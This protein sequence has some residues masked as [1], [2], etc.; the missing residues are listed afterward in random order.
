MD[1]IS[2][3]RAAYLIPFIDVLRDIGAPVTRDLEQAKLPAM[4]EETP[5]EFVSNVLI[6]DY[7]AKSERREDIDDLGWLWAEQF[8]ASIFSAELLA[9]LQHLPTVKL[10]LD[11]FACLS[12]LEDSDVSIGIVESNG[13]AEVF[14][15]IPPITGLN[16]L[17]ISEWT[18]VTALIETIR[19]ITGDNWS[20]DE[21]RFKSDFRVCNAAREA[22]PDT[23]FRTRSAHTSIIMPSSVLAASQLTYGT[24]PVPVLNIPETLDGMENLKR[25]IRPYLREGA[26]KM[27]AFAEMMQVSPR[28]LQRKLQQAGTSFSDLIEI[29]RFEMATEILAMSD[30]PLIDV[31]MMLGF[32]NQ[33]NFGRSFR[34]IAGI[35]PGKYRRE[36]IGQERAG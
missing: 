33:S 35:S 23:R 1:K 34:R 28:S 25:L 16:G 18:Q 31:A 13:S 15:D 9:A 19:S 8:S 14:C 29:A 27:S 7:L 30:M 20:P 32:E 3:C 17:H 36:V 24:A 11:R 5:E 10:R 22:N 4:V 2:T 21:V 26:P 6:D 12:K